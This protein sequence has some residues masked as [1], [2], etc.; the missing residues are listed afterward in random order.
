[1][2]KK[3][4]QGRGPGQ[5]SA[6][7]A[8][9]VLKIF[10]DQG[11]PLTRK[12]LE[13]A[14]D[15]AQNDRHKLHFTLDN[16]IESGKIIVIQGA[17][18][19]TENMSLL[20]G[21]LEVQ[22]SGVGFVLPDDK[23]RKDIFINPRDF[24]DA[25]HGDR[26][27]AALSGSGE[28][29]RPEG[30]IVRVIERGHAVLASRVIRRVGTGMYLCRPAD[31]RFPLNFMA[32][33]GA[34]AA[35][36]A[37]GDIVRL[38]PGDKLE[39]QVYAAAIE[40]VM[41]AEEDVGVQERL[42]KY[43]HDIPTD[44]PAGV[45]EDAA[46]LPLVPSESDFAG[47]KDLRK[48]PLVTIDGAKARDFDDAVHVKK[49]R[50][51]FTLT[52]AIADVS[53]YVSPDSRLDDEAAQ[54]ANSYYFPAS[55]EPMLPEALSN[56][57]CSLNPGVPR[58]AMVA[59]MNFSAKGVPGKSCFYPAV[60]QSAARLT[61]SQ[62][63][64]AVIE[65]D[66]EEREK[67]AAVLPMLET[68][69]K[70]ARLLHAV[71]RERGS[72]DFDLPDPEILLNLS[73]ETVDIR[74]RP[75]NFA[76]Q[77]IEEFMLAANEAVAGFLTEHGAAAL[78]R[79]HPEPDPDKLKNL[80]AMLARTDLA[81]H[82]PKEPTTKGL[83]MLLAAAADTDLGFLVSRLT[84]RTMMQ[85][86]YSPALSGHFGLA[87][88]CYCHFTSPIRRYAD[89]VI[90]RSLKAALGIDVKNAP[91]VKNLQKLSEHL[92]TRERAGMEAE[93]EILKR[94]TVLFLRDKTGQEFSGV[95]SSMADFGFWVELSEVMAEGMV[96][97]SSLSDDY[98]TFFPDR[99]EILGSRTGRRLVLGQTV[100]V[101]LTDVGIGRLEVNLRLK[102][103]AK[104][105]K[106]NEASP[107]PGGGEKAKSGRG[108]RSRRGGRGGRGG[109]KKK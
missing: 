73:G 86:K 17:Y 42:V 27:V 1:M 44:F 59:E 100:Q 16:L 22:R 105:A 46:R 41:G 80:F 108:G 66:P 58:M 15:L 97:L 30:R 98:Y 4:N 92:S 12:E 72:L 90:H 10:R 70:L 85:A 9:R 51:G 57:L 71:R 40:E 77:I 76:H 38:R 103:S 62:V 102:D 91:A 107:P 2:A 79:I 67:I 21:V 24:G 18:G 32:E 68:A 104:P 96:R 50:T 83:Q 19:L 93:R 81:V 89:L 109:G 54:R 43:G 7:D 84:L 39:Y 29:R 45:L 99:Q 23:R 64:R 3:K 6:L 25:W 31:P 53:H 28:K 74:Q 95:I 8:A 56:G 33:T 20:S 82:L 94:L 52:V 60:I 75:R 37:P 47:R 26:V 63:N 69:E 106:G 5:S 48:T 34:G 65:G 61:Y 87:S 11:K 36:L 55:V 88:P 35:E 13:Y 49:T 78:Y 101:V 14:L